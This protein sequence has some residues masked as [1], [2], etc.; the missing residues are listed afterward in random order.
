MDW[1][2]FISSIIGSLVWPATIIAGF[3]IL[4]AYLPA[5]F[6]FIERLKYKDF[7]VEFRKSVKELA[8]KSQTALPAPDDEQTVAPRNRLYSLAE[9]SPRSAIL[10]AWLQ[11]ETA[12]AE[13]IQSK[14]PEHTGK[15]RM[16]APLRLGEMLNRSQIINNA[17]R[18]IFNR[19]RDLR[20]KAVHIGDATFNPIEVTEY[21]DLASSLASQ[22]RRGTYGS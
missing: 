6:P 20:N 16:L 18:E 14:S 5:I 8:E 22:I 17:Q 13:A 4:K 7:E 15:S 19:L 9:L 12:A 3:F 1:L 2:Q 21:I 11:V 10:E